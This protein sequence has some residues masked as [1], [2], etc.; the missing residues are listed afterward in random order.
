[1]PSKTEHV[2]YLKND[3]TR[4]KSFLTSG[5][6]GLI[7]N[8]KID[9]KINVQWANNEPF[10]LRFPVKNWDIKEFNNWVNREQI[11]HE[12]IEFAKD[13]QA[14]CYFHTVNVEKKELDIIFYDEIGFWGIQSKE[15][16]ELL[17]EHKNVTQI[18]VYIN[19]PGGVIYDAIAIYNQ[20]KAHKANIY[21]KVDGIA[22]S[23]ATIVM[24]AADIIEMPSNTTMMIHKPLFSMLYGVNSED[25][26]QAKDELDRLEDIIIAMYLSRSNKSKSELKGMLAATT[27]M[28]ASLAKEY[29]F[30]DILSDE[31][32]ILN[33]FD[34]SKYDYQKPQQILNMFDIN[35]CPKPTD[36][37]TSKNKIIE[38]VKSLLN[39]TNKKKEAATMSKP[40]DDQITNL[41]ND[42]KSLNEKVVKFEGENKVLKTENEVMKAALDANNKAMAEQAEKALR[43]NF[44]AFVNKKIAECKVKPADKDT[45]ISTLMNH[46]VID[47]GNFTEEKKDTPNVDSYKN[48]LNSLPV[49][50]DLKEQASKD[51]AVDDDSDDSVYAK[52]LEYIAEQKKLGKHIN[53]SQAIKAVS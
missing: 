24:M 42:V 25:L 12:D 29:G 37:S 2:I 34:F 39:I 41:V 32:E 23:A 19:S 21:V 4:Q 52:A 1:M 33:R 10:A 6:T 46:Y 48:L 20:L 7:Q 53:L 43:N 45:H 51:D 47:S 18:N 44:E 9:E 36:D 13:S 27:Y 35:H 40:T 31:I 26:E 3:F 11:E 8:K 15:F 38:T 14:P 28:T 16:A 49:I 30:V 50:V 17:N 22:A 5:S